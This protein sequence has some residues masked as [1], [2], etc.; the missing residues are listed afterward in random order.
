MSK[1]TLPD[2]FLRNTLNNLGKKR[3]SRSGYFLAG[4]NL[5]G[6][7][8]NLAAMP[9]RF[10]CIDGITDTVK[11]EIKETRKEISSCFASTFACFNS[12]TSDFFS[13][14]TYWWKS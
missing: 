4:D 11:H 3:N 9:R 8:S 14:K 13:S 5:P 2:G 1:I 6:L 10:E 7:V 12:A